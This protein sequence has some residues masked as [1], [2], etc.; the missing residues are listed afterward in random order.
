MDLL[1]TELYNFDIMAFTE[2]WLNT[3][4][5]NEDIMLPSFHHPERKDRINDSHGGVLVYVKDS[6][7]K[8]RRND[9]EIARL[10]CIW[11]EI[12]LNKK[13]ILLGTFYRPP[14]SD[15]TYYTIIE[16]SIN[17][18]VDTGIADIVIIGDFNY[19]ML[20]DQTARKIM[21]LC[22]HFGLEQTIADHTHFT[23]NSSSLIDLLMVSNKSNLIVSGVA[24]PFLDQQVRYHCPIYGIFKF[25]KPISKSFTRT[26]LSYDQ[27]DFNTM[28]YNV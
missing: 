8:I 13:H 7:N 16:D 9:L 26:I 5:A 28:R 17:L 27:G 15:S 24:D 3:S 20:S 25:R 14:S 10:E 18:A 6:I 4:V 1:Q 19:N 23:E 12:I 11:I 21:S 2:T 22:H